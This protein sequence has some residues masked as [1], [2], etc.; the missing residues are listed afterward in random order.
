MTLHV[1]VND[2]GG[3]LVVLVLVH[4]VTDDGEQVES[5]QD[6][7]SQVHI[8][9][10]VELRLVNTA[11]RVSGCNN[12][13]ASLERRNNTSLGDRD[14]LL[15]HGFV[16][17]GS[18]LFV[19]LIELIDEADTLIGKDKRATFEGPLTRDRIFMYT[20]CQTDSTSTLTCRVHNAV[21]D[22]LDVL[23]EL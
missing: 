20:G 14:G 12:R 17:R 22:L 10:E 13:A 6:R 3:Q 18:V 11:D 7:V 16:D 2:E 8:I 5:R 1:R 19:H 15:L 4:F 9:I 23:Q 21:I